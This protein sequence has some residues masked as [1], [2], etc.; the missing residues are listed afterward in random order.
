MDLAVDVRIEGRLAFVTPVGEIDVYTAPKLREVLIT[1]FNKAAPKIC[2]IDMT[3]VEY[4]DSTGMGVLV[5]G[6][7]RAWARGSE[8]ALIRPSERVMKQFRI[9]GLSRVFPMYGSADEV[10]ADRRWVNWERSA[11]AL[12]DEE[13]AVIGFPIWIYVPDRDLVRAVLTAL[14]HLIP[15]FELEIVY[16]SRLGLR[17]GRELGARRRSGSLPDSASATEQ[18]ALLRAALEGTANG[19]TQWQEVAAT[20]LVKL[21]RG[22]SQAVVQVGSLMIV[23]FRG[24]LEVRN[25]TQPE[26][27]HWYDRQDLKMNPEAAM[28]TLRTPP[29]PA[30]MRAARLT[31]ETMEIIERGWYVNGDGEQVELGE[32]TDQV[33]VREEGTVRKSW[34]RTKA[35]TRVEVVEETTLQAAARLG[36]GVLVLNF[37]A[38]GPLGNGFTGG[39]HAQETSLV[40][41]TTLHLSLRAA[42][43]FYAVQDAKVAPLYRHHVAYSPVVRVFRDDDGALLAEPYTVSVLS[44]VAPGAG[45]PRKENLH[46]TLVE[47]IW[48][49]LAVAQEYRHRTLVLGAWGCGGAGNDPAVIAEAFR[50]RLEGAPFERVVFAVV[51]EPALSAFRR[52]FRG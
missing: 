19:L 11:D 50:A 7:K 33:V 49:L 12:L 8:V 41:A 38:P 46:E 42:S 27:R 23:K 48:H 1:L 51:G 9:T 45:P 36:D 28:A 21:L 25:L 6:L 2:V 15:A 26:L 18:S 5:G 3:R 37:A 29:T 31:A 17:Y 4:L 40:R 47:R 52:V 39:E 34:R 20:S 44:A 32:K 13:A 43:A 24:H 35:V 10:R 30:E 16:S 14:E 22:G